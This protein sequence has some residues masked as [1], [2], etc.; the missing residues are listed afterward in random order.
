LQKICT[1]HSRAILSRVRRRKK[2]PWLCGFLGTKLSAVVFGQHIH[3]LL[4]LV[5]FF[6]WGCLKDTVYN[7]NLP[8][9]EEL[10]ENIHR[11]I[12][13]IPAEQLQRVNQNFFCQCEEFLRIEGQ[14]FQQ[15]L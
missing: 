8:T 7:S 10:K 3:P 1:S 15:L 11:E 4:I 2:T 13:N 14:H 5:I 12:A 9:E 6:F